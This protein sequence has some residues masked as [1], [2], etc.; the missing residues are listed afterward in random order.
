MR[1]YRAFNEARKF[2]CSLNFKGVNDWYKFCLSGNRPSDI[3]SNPSQV[4]KDKGWNGFGDWLGT[5]KSKGVYIRRE[6]WAFEKAREFARM[7]GL[8]SRKEWEEYAKSGK[9]PKDIPKSP[10]GVYKDKGWIGIRDWLGSG[11][12]MCKY[13]TYNQLV[14]I[15]RKAKIKSHKEYMEWFKKT[16]ATSNGKWIKNGGIPANPDRYYGDRGQWKSWGVFLGTKRIANQ[17]KNDPP[18][19][20]KKT[21]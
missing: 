2:A 8:G 20:R 5:G 9:R 15:V 18:L 1:K 6:F 19:R 17:L 12:D 21:S 14:K 16:K 3:P 4:Y 13:P 10:Q 11:L 7:L